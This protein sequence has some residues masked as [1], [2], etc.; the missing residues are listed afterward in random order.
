MPCEFRGTDGLCPLSIGLEVL[1]AN[2]TLLLGEIGAVVGRQT[3]VNL[4]AGRFPNIRKEMGGE[5]WRG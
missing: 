2:G 1:A 4:E 5:R 3:S